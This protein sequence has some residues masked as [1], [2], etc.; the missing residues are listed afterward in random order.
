MSSL[1]DQL[2]KAGIVDKKKLK[3]AKLSQH[4]QSKKIPKG[5]KSVDLNKLQAEA[6]LAK[7]VAKD[8]ALNK[9]NKRLADEKAVQAQIIQ[10]IK[11]NTIDCKN[12]DVSFQFTDNNVIKKIYVNALLQKQLSKGIVGIAK[13]NES[14]VII[15]SVVAVK[16]TQRDESS[17]IVM[18]DNIETE[19][20]IDD[21]YADYQIPDDLMW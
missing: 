17:I 6:N 1:Q 7:R 10:L 18:N 2:L 8:K 21:A 5:Q 12:G 14:Y 9:E 11:A 16:I 19:S 13:L 20:D 3:K 15:P 4:S